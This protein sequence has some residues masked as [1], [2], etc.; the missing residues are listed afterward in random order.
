MT[1]FGLFGCRP[2]ADLSVF[3]DEFL[4]TAPV[5]DYLSDLNAIRAAI[6][7]ARENFRD[8]EAALFWCDGEFSVQADR[9]VKRAH[10][11]DTVPLMLIT[12]PQYCEIFLRTLNLWKD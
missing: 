11:D 12:A 10:Y 9:V 5:P 3:S 2:G 6:D 4:C 1:S 8:I 7:Y